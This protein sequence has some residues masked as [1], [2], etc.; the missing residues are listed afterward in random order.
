MVFC[1]NAVVIAYVYLGKIYIYL[2]KQVLLGCKIIDVFNKDMVCFL[3]MQ[4][5]FKMSAVWAEFIN[6][7]WLQNGYKNF[8]T[9]EKINIFRKYD[10]R[11]PRK[12]A[13]CHIRFPQPNPWGWSYR[14]FWSCGYYH[15]VIWWLEPSKKLSTAIL[16]EIKGRFLNFPSPKEEI[17]LFLFFRIYD[18]ITLN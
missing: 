4:I 16:W 5:L 9:T 2:W 15:W 8:E 3:V 14:R 12:Q 11:K 10:N 13:I 18:R 17:R 1:I 6:V 7:S